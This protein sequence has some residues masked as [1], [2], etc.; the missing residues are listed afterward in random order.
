MITTILQY[1]LKQLLRKRV[2]W[3]LLLFILLGG[4][5][6]IAYGWL[7]YQHY[8]TQ[9]DEVQ[10]KQAETYAELA[11]K[12]DTLTQL[13]DQAPERLNSL[14]TPSWLIAVPPIFHLVTWFIE[15]T[16]PWGNA[17]NKLPIN[18][19]NCTAMSICRNWRKSTTPN[20]FW[21]GILTSALYWFICCP[22][23]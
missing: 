13:G 14:A 16:W 8:R 6:A 22:C 5:Y 11:P 19:F 3:A 9:I 15:C 2:G 21:P 23:W 4:G 20:S 12:Y 7:N 10:Q 1:E 18:A 17:I